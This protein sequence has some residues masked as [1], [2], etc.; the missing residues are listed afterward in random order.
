MWSSRFL[1]CLLTAGQLYL[2]NLVHILEAGWY[3]LMHYLPICSF[4]FLA[5]SLSYC[6]RCIHCCALFNTL[7]Y[8][9]VLSE[10][11]RW[12]FVCVHFLKP[13][14]LLRFW[15]RVESNKMK[16][17]IHLPRFCPGQRNR[18]GFVC[19]GHLQQKHTWIGWYFWHD[20]NPQMVQCV[21]LICNEK[22]EGAETCSWWFNFLVNSCTSFPVVCLD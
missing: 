19:P 13:Q 12:L 14:A 2:L 20:Q 4:N 21:L 6:I 22:E 17:A 16:W 18:E 3:S 9:I 11:Q 7:K 8:W 1:C 15:N 5:Y 10:H